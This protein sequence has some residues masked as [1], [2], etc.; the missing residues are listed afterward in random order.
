LGTVAFPT[1]EKNQNTPD[2]II[3]AVMAPL[4]MPMQCEHTH[5]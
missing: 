3:D 5:W 1:A 4:S 2:Q